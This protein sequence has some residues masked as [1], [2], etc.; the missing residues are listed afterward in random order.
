M[1][2]QKQQGDVLFCK[3]DSIPEGAKRTPAKDNKYVLAEGEATGHAH[4][5]EADN[6]ELFERDGVLYVST[7]GLSTVTHEEHK[8]LVLDDGVW[9]VGRVVEIDPFEAETHRVRD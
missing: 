1:I 5:M 7:V 9:E 2:T 3:L 4:C 6:V 8:E